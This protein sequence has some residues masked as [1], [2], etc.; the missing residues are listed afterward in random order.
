MSPLYL[1]ALHR[2]LWGKEGGMGMEA[3]VTLTL[4]TLPWFA[5]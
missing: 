3:P 4:P 5:P 2:M 1:A